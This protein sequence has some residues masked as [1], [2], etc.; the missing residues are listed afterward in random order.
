M[1]AVAQQGSID[2]S[3]LES[4]REVIQRRPRDADALFALAKASLANP[5]PN[6]SH[7]NDSIRLYVQGLSIAH[8]RSAERRE[9]VMLLD[10][11]GE[12][13]LLIQVLGPLL[14]EDPRDPV[15]LELQSLHLVRLGRD[16]QAAASAAAWSS[17][18]LQNPRAQLTQSLSGPSTSTSVQPAT[19]ESNQSTLTTAQRLAHIALLV[20]DENAAE[21][22][23]QLDALTSDSAFDPRC[24]RYAVY[25]L[26]QLG[27]FAK[28]DALAAKLDPSVDESLATAFALRELD[29]GNVSAARKRLEQAT[30]PKDPS[31]RAAQLGLTCLLATWAQDAAVAQRTLEQL[32]AIPVEYSGPWS[33]ALRIITSESIDETLARELLPCLQ[34]S[35]R[36]EEG[37]IL[38]QIAMAEC[39]VALKQK[40]KAFR[41][42]DEVAR[43]PAGWS[44]ATR[45]TVEHSLAGNDFARAVSAARFA[46]QRSGKTVESGVLLAKTTARTRP[47][48][49]DLQ[50]HLALLREL[51]QIVPDELSLVGPLA[52]ALT[53][54]G[55]SPGAVSVIKQAL[56]RSAPIEPRY[57]L[58][59]AEISQRNRFG[60]E[61]ELLDRAQTVAG[62]SPDILL[63]RSRTLHRNGDTARALQELRAAQQASASKNLDLAVAIFLSEIRSADAIAAWESLARAYPKDLPIQL[64]Y[65]GVVNEADAA[66]SVIQRIQAIDPSN[67]AAELAEIKLLLSSEQSPQD[68]EAALLRLNRLTE[69]RPDLAEATLLL[70][71][72]LL[73]S[74]DLELAARRWEAAYSRAPADVGVLSVGAQLL[75]RQGQFARASE[76]L[77]KLEVS[78]AGL[79][80]AQQLLV[81]RLELALGR[82]LRSLTVIEKYGLSTRDAKLLLA[83][84]RFR[85]GDTAVGNSILDELLR[86]PDLATLLFAASVA[87]SQGDRSRADDYLAKALQLNVLE[88]SE[89][90]KLA[91]TFIARREASGVQTLVTKGTVSNDTVI[92]I[93]AE[94]VRQGE[95]DAAINLLKDAATR[96][97]NPR[98]L[99]QRLEVESQARTLVR[100]KYF[101]L[102]GALLERPEDQDVRDLTTFACSFPEKPLREQQEMLDSL[103]QR[104]RN[105]YVAQVFLAERYLAV[106]QPLAAA[107]AARRASDLDKAAS[108][109]LFIAALSELQAGSTTRCAETIRQLRDR[110]PADSAA[111]DVIDVENLLRGKRYS[112]ILDRYEARAQV[113]GSMPDEIRMALA[114]AFAARNRLSDAS[115]VLEPLLRLDSSFTS[116][117]MSRVSQRLDPQLATPAIELCRPFVQQRALP[118]ERVSYEV[119]LGQ[120]RR[121]SGAESHTPPVEQIIRSLGIELRE[122]LTDSVVKLIEYSLSG[123][124]AAAAVR[125]CD[126]A[127][128]TRPQDIKLWR[129]R[130]QLLS[131]TNQW[132]L[133]LQA[134]DEAIRLSDR[135][136][137]MH[138]VRSRCLRE[139]KRSE[140]ALIAISR[141]VALDPFNPQWVLEQIE[142]EEEAGKLD[143]ARERIPALRWLLREPE[144]WP[145]ELVKAAQT[146]SLRLQPAPATQAAQG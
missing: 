90:L 66:R 58:E 55:D 18:D 80:E 50:D 142:L 81:A 22:A 109:P 77:D 42:L 121:R 14:E 106:N 113:A 128:S 94:W 51:Y 133:A 45:R 39:F 17:V 40:D 35:T 10:L 36:V 9:L 43:T 132:E 41:L 53:D 108:R 104:T 100:Q 144:V 93:A 33:A 97:Q 29:R 1:A 11:L 69:R 20:R 60:L 21:G 143:T 76:L 3:V 75:L 54:T 98:E 119:S 72:A 47:S 46:F 74:G 123:G 5:Q 8:H 112:D 68:R 61:M 122:L 88:S 6:R 65:L 125:L 118:A 19:A 49:Q 32:A 30:L 7:L 110:L 139:L 28:A 126:E 79:S 102:A 63:A 16:Q 114:E 137:T 52:V 111:P 34:V 135:S 138:S 136:P 15:L 96:S 116:A 71:N 26:D 64:Q 59:W 130:A 48:G 92:R 134:A 25:L 82:P 13:E 85:L 73:R 67:E 115:A 56:A 70:V 27:A 99:E 37:A 23:M 44:L 107:Q 141:A 103:A 131:A 12:S 95:V 24:G 57:L 145:A 86:E 38:P 120:V 124:D 129:A 127:L 101:E 91:N 4:L 87:D 84:A 140:D 105:S 78:L 89:Q 117:W 62:P 83:E 31:K 2:G 146:L